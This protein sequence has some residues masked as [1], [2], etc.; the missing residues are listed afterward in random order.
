MTTAP[1]PD[2]PKE[3][4]V[5]LKETTLGS[6]VN[7][8][9]TF[10]TIVGSF[11]FNYKFIGGNDALDILLFLVFFMFGIGKAANYK[12]MKQLIDE[13]SKGGTHAG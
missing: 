8:V 6:I 1:M 5:F 7:D 9:F 2:K 3:K 12:K 10:S 11:W 4:I 13:E